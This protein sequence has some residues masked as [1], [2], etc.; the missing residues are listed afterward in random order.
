[1]TGEQE[2]MVILNTSALHRLKSLLLKSFWHLFQ[3]RGME[4]IMSPCGQ[5]ESTKTCC[6]LHLHKITI[7]KAKRMLLVP[8][9]DHLAIVLNSAWG[10]V[11]SA[12]KIN[13]LEEFRN[14]CLGIHYESSDRARCRPTSRQDP[15]AHAQKNH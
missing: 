5:C 6:G 11:T 10:T 12:L 13:A 4:P 9:C 7:K 2:Q 15:C 8:W 3:T 14:I 1:M